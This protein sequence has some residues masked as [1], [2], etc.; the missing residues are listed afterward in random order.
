MGL[1]TS[2]YT[3]IDKQR[4]PVW[5]IDTSFW[6]GQID[7]VKFKNAG[8]TF[9]IIKMLD[10]TGLDA[11]FERNYFSAI[12]AD[13]YVS[14]YQWLYSD[15]KQSVETQ[16]KK[17]AEM[18]DKYPVDFYPAIDYEWSSINP[19]R[20]DL[21][22]YLAV[23]K[24]CSK[25]SPMIYSA[26]GYLND[27]AY[28]LSSDFAEYPL[29]V[30]HYG[31]SNPEVSKPFT[32]WLFWQ[33]TEKADGVSLGSSKYG[34]EEID[35]NYFNGSLSEFVEICNHSGGT[36]VISSP[37]VDVIVPNGKT[38]LVNTDVLNVRPEPNTSK[39]PVTKVYR[40]ETLKG[41]SI[42]PDKKWAK[43]ITSKNIVGW[44]SLTYLQETVLSEE[45]NPQESSNLPIGSVEVLSTEHL[46]GGK[47]VYYRWK[48]YTSHGEIICHIVHVAREYAEVFV[49]P[50]PSGVSYVHSFL[51]KYKL[52]LAINGDGFA[53]QKKGSQWQLI[54]AGQSAS[55]G[56]PYGTVNTEGAIYISK[57]G[58]PSFV[59]PSG[60][61]LWN[62]IA[63]P[64]KLVENGSKAKITRTDVD[65]RTAL[66]F[67]ENGDI[68][69]LTVDG[70][71]TYNAHR[72]GASFDELAEIMLDNGAWMAVN[73]DG[74]GSTT[75]VAEG[76]DGQPRILNAPCGENQIT[77]G[78]RLYRL[79]AVANHFGIYIK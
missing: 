68:I 38:Y 10:G 13:V 56:Q 58:T 4:F 3:P 19:T 26:P 40:G 57:D 28:A 7:W 64:N 50:R 36:P 9:A 35:A 41:I 44:C 71:E 22:K 31:V 18:L 24:S 75:L 62:A 47:A 67:K 66:G 8:G 74:G 45:E 55:R 63:F 20:E 6:T 60:K 59:R 16:A 54:M 48:K 37:P 73:L 21:K 49:T 43:I 76:A 77:V 23:F 53:S 52:Q 51:K 1:F 33:F 42:S 14:T 27:G 11:W 79:R 46:F 39:N 17:Y 65:P 12:A 70:K 32:S 72:T 2:K 25:Y 34:E 29:W 61:D 5:G 78:G 15:R 30:A 69:L